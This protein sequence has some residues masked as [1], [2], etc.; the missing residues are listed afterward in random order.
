MSSGMDAHGV[1][2]QLTFVT[3]PL[4][5]LHDVPRIA[6]RACRTL[7]INPLLCVYVCVS[8][9]VCVCLNMSRRMCQNARRAACACE[10][11]HRGGGD[12]D[13]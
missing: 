7:L 1:L 10:A 8:V 4:F 5:T 13:G 11:D 12:A 6:R 9:L 3:H 2:L